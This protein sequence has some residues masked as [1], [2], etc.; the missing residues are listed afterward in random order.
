MS[1]DVDYDE[2]KKQRDMD[3]VEKIRLAVTHKVTLYSDYKQRE[4]R[5]AVCDESGNVLWYGRLFDEI[6]EQ[7]SGELEAAQ[8]ACWLARKI[9]DAAGAEGIALTLFVDAEYLTYQEHPKQKGFRLTEFCN[10]NRISLNI[11]H[12]PGTENPADKW[13]TERGFKKWSDNNLAELAVTV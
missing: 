11:L 10:K 5:Y 3:S 7:S 2:L 13:T 8:N 9:G 4:G 12:V 6:L 1:I